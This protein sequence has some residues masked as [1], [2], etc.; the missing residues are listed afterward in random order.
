MMD[1][2]EVEC[3]EVFLKEQEKLLKERVVETL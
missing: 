1:G 3:A 2:Y